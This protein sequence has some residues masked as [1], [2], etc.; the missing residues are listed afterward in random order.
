MSC[1]LATNL[2]FV[3]G[4]DDKN[5]PDNPSN[6]VPDPEGTIMVSM[7]NT[8]N[9]GTYISP[10]GCTDGFYI[11]EDD[12]FYG[13]WYGWKFA[14]IGKMN[15]L[16]NVTNIPM[17]GWADKVAVVP[18]YGY[19]G[20]SISYSSASIA[21]SKTFKVAYARIYV[22]SWITSAAS[23]GIIGAEV[24]YQSPFSFKPNAKEIT[25]SSTIINLPASGTWHSN[26][27]WA[28]HDIKIEVSPFNANWSVTSTD[29]SWC[30]VLIN[31]LNSF[32]V[33]Y[34]KNPNGTHRTTTLTVKVEGLPDKT[35]TVTQAGE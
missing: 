16:G 32:E 29:D 26:W 14:T 17:S 20:C 12:N 28:S 21:P 27:G 10:D 3:A 6:S 25:L 24:K 2:F 33:N 15:G 13:S 22:T 9:G 19:V 34:Q 5:D 31:N 7:R 18:G 30:Q 23:G 4:C 35:I 1:L 8:N 11:G